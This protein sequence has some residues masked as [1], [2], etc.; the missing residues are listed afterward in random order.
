MVLYYYVM[1]A[2]WLV[3]ENGTNINHVSHYSVFLDRRY[4][5][6]TKA[7]QNRKL[8][9]N[10]ERSRNC[11]EW[12][13]FLSASMGLCARYVLFYR[14]WVPASLKMLDAVRILQLVCLFM[15]RVGVFKKMY[16]KVRLTNWSDYIS[17][18]LSLSLS[19]THTHTHTRTHA[20]THTHTHRHTHTYTHKRIHAH[21]ASFL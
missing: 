2:S 8:W 10:F 15:T 19:L 9:V 20:R 14:I 6:P 11:T 17:L 1:V 13:R 21:S 5:M 7:Q 3:R 18:S 12:L 4:S 16:A